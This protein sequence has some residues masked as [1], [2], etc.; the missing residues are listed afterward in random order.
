MELGA[1]AG[2]AIHGDTLNITQLKKG[3]LSL[4]KAMVELYQYLQYDTEE[5]VIHCSAEYPWVYGK[6][7]NFLH[8]F[9]P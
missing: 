9:K 5:T 3:L 7:P 2:G 6:S 1:G 4:S 8:L